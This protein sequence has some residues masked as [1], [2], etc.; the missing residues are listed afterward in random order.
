M[1][2]ESDRP[3]IKIVI[4]VAEHLEKGPAANRAAVIATGLAAHVPDMIGANAITKDNKSVLGFTQISIPILIARQNVSLVDLSQKAESLGCTVIIFLAR[5]QGVRSYLEYVE[6]IKNTNYADL[7]I[8]GIGISGETKTVT[9]LTG[10][11]PSLR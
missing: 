11:L 5:A 10:N 8:D 7:D 2:T 1:K 9:K 6:S 4:V 3:E